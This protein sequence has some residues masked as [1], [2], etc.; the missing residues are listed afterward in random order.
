MS[1]ADSGG[2]ALFFSLSPILIT[3]PRLPPEEGASKAGGPGQTAIRT[4]PAFPRQAQ[5]HALYLLLSRA[6]GSESQ[7]ARRNDI[8]G[9][10]LPCTLYEPVG[11]PP[12]PV[13]RQQPQL[14]HR[15]LVPGLLFWFWGHSEPS[16]ALSFCVSP[17]VHPKDPH[18]HSG[19]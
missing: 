2:R 19:E 17:Q 9:D 10:S 4:C 8:P 15:R 16:N 1:L 12:L 18:W 3:A 13:S 7:N 11:F 5:H 6:P 14:H